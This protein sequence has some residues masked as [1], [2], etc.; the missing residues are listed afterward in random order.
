[1]LHR[2]DSLRQWLVIF[3][4]LPR[5]YFR[6]ISYGFHIADQFLH[7]VVLEYILPLFSFSDKLLMREWVEF[8]DS[9]ECLFLDLEKQGRSS[10]KWIIIVWKLIWLVQKDADISKVRT[11]LKRPIIQESVFAHYIDLALQDE[12]NVFWLLASYYNWWNCVNCWPTFTFVMFVVFVEVWAIVETAILENVSLQ[13]RLNLIGFLEYI[14]K[15]VVV[16]F[17]K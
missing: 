9:L 4:N 10:V 15:K 2:V 8:A 3:L 17:K 11:F 1:M 14:A 16:I 6:V 7:F 13:I 12:I 5:D